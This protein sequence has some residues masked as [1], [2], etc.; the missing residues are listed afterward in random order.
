MLTKVWAGTES[1]PQAIARIQ[2]AR[3]ESA[4]VLNAFAAAWYAAPYTWT[5]TNVW[6]AP[7]MKNPLDLQIYA[8][9]IGRLKPKTIL[10]TGTAWG[11]SAL[12]YALAQDI[13]NIEGGR[14]Y[15][16][17]VEAREHL[18]QHARITYVHG[19]STD[20]DLI[21]ALLDDC[22]RPLLVTLDADHSVEHVAAELALITPYVRVGEY[23]IVEDTN[24]SWPDNRG[25]MGAV[26]DLL[27]A[28]P[29]CWVQD[30]WCERYWL[31]CHP[32]GWLQRRAEPAAE[33]AA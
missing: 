11:G 21:R 27:A 6:G 16:I 30:V 19:S 4:D 20:P 33:G 24:I 13:W 22:P 32:G 31:T 26:E 3:A 18:P 1:M 2:Q 8:E 17:D 23:C 15:T 29:G 14:V 7:A 10:E 5:S 28:E 25:A 12:H 9:L